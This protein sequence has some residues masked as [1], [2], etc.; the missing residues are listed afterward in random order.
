MPPM[1]FYIEPTMRAFKKAVNADRIK[2]GGVEAKKLEKLRRRKIKALEDTARQAEKD[3]KALEKYRKQYEKKK[4][5][6][7]AAAARKLQRKLK[8]K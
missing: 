1:I 5:R 7:E 8:K 6:E 2:H 3:A 4:A